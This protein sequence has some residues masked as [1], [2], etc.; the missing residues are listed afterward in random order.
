M[1]WD[2]IC[3]CVHGETLRFILEM[4][5]EILFHILNILQFKPGISLIIFLTFK[6]KASYFGSQKASHF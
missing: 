3:K 6:N 1:T 2:N 4:E 5:R